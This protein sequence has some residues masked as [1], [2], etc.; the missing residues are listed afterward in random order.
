MVFLE[1]KNRKEV[2]L[3]MPIPPAVILICQLEIDI[4]S[5]TRQAPRE[6]ET[7]KKGCLHLTQ[8]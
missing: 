4:T 5:A 3:A 1:I 2:L 6:F 7:E 8:V